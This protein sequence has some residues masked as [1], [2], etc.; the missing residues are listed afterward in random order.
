MEAGGSVLVL[1]RL[2]GVCR[3]CGATDSLLLVPS[4]HALRRFVESG[5]RTYTECRFEACEP[6]FE[7]VLA[8]Y[9]CKNG[10][11]TAALHERRL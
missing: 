4:A 11:K 10:D 5:G 6:Q 2:S 8:I 9:G 3:T 1:E 7:E